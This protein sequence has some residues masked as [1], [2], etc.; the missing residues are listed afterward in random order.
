[1]IE[2]PP[3]LVIKGARNRPTIAQIDAFKDI[4]SGFVVDA[5]FGRGALDSAIVPLRLDRRIAGPAVT[6][7][8][9]PGDMLATLGALSVLAPGDVLVGG[10][11]GWQGCAAG[12]DRLCG[13]AANAG[14][15]AFV[16]DGPVRD[17]EG[18]ERIGLPVW[19]TGLMPASP[20]TTG[21]GTIGGRMS[22]GGLWVSSGDMVVADR[23]GV[24]IVPF[25]EIDA[26]IARLEKV[27]QLEEALDKEVSK[28]LR[29]PSSI[30]D[31]L[32]SDEVRHE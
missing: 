17:I 16:T 2:E 9:P 25:D 23:D 15:V 20:F 18:I 7:D 21:P 24:V 13:M 3:R 26:V 32:N 19:C 5:M 12:G 1:M 6:A 4:P 29:L 11:Q 14:A 22:F 31:L 28:G 27:Q 30:H 10:A 8:N